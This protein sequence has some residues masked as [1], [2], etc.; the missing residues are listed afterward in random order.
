MADAVT[1]LDLIVGFD[2][3]DANATK[4]ASRFIPFDGF[5][6]SLKEDG[7]RGKRVG[8]LRHSFSNN[9]PKGTMEANTFEAHFQTMR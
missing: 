2:P 8:I 4:D 5:Q 6:K 7:L 9:Y 1:L 3:L